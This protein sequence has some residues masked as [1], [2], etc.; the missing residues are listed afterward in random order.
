MNGLNFTDGLGFDLQG[1][2]RVEKHPDGWYVL[3]EGMLCPVDD[4]K[5]GDG[6]I[7]EIQ[8]NRAKK[9]T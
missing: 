8:A 7:A 5:D 9:S 3:G 1:L 6:L 4:E 2:L